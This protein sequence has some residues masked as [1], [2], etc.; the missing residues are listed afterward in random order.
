MSLSLL[1]FAG[2]AS[3]VDE[4]GVVHVIYG[5]GSGLTDLDNQ[6]WHQDVASVRNVV[7]LA[8]HFGICP[9]L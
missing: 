1:T 6:L 8:D 4:A 2:Q 7:E 3:L 9:C 5:S